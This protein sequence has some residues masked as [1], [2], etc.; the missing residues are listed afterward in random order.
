M[1]I[2]KFISPEVAKIG[3]RSNAIISSLNTAVRNYYTLEEM[4]RPCR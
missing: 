4:Q 2:L 1:L 3:G